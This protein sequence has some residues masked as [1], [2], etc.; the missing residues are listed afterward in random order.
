MLGQINN[1]S[2]KEKE[3]LNPAQIIFSILSGVLLALS[4]SIPSLSFLAWFSL[5]PFFISLYNY[6]NTG[7]QGFQLSFIFSLTYYLG[8][9]HWLFRLHPLTWVGFTETQSILIITAGWLTFSLI[10][11]IGLS[12]VGFLVT[13]LKP[14][15]INRIILPVCVWIIIEWI[16]S[17]GAT[18]FTW[19]RLA[20]SQFENI[21]LIQ[22]SNLFGNLFVSGLIVL[23]NVVLALSIIDFQKN[24]F[25]LKPIITTLIIFLLNLGYGFYSVNQ[26]ND[27]GK[28]INATIIQGNI[29][30]DQ[31]WDMQAIDMF[32]LYSSLTKDALKQYPKT[33]LVVWPESAITD[34]VDINNN[35]TI[36]YPEI[37]NK[38]KEITR[39]NNIYLT[40]GIFT[41]KFPEPRKYDI[42][43]SIITVSPK[44]EIVGTYSKRH[45]VPFGEY[46][47]FR[48]ILEKIVP[49]IT[50]INALGSDVTQGLDTS[51]INTSFGKIGGLVCYDSILPQLTRYS[52]NDGAELLVLV[53]NDSWY[54]DSIG[55]YEHNG[56]SVFRAIETSRYMVR[57]ANTG[58]STIISPNGEIMSKLD[59]LTKGFIS[60]TVRA[61]NTITLYSK[62]GDIIAIISLIVLSLII[63]TRKNDDLLLMSDE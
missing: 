61:R 33:N 49:S 55:V 8:L 50:K 35:R 14:K 25:T 47:P 29:L 45:L 39:N 12:F 62:L 10:E 31:K 13:S 38:M 11:S 19:G 9:L 26:V 6:K 24:K 52:V 34:A 27:D 30:S 1:I 4:F 37:L 17:L 51:L 43:N 63:L 7:K 58:I 54:K 16:Q 22:S 36:K 21:H 28:E 46:L 53:T 20:L 60:N 2:L 56:Q 44:S 42:S 57:A 18:G 5:I 59:P 3:K 15:G 32:N 48:N 40:T 23:V 41:I